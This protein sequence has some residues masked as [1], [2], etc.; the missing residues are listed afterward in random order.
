MSWPGSEHAQSSPRAVPFTD[1]M[2]ANHDNDDSFP[3]S[4]SD[5]TGAL[6]PLPSP[7]AEVLHK[8]AM[9]VAPTQEDADEDASSAAS[10]I[11]AYARLDF[12][13]YTFFVQTLQVVLGR[14][15]N[16]EIQSSQHAVDVH[17][18]SKKA[19]SRRHAKIFYNFGT[20]QFEISIMGRNGA[21]VDDLFVEKGITLPLVDGTKVQIGDIS[22]TFVLP[23]IEPSEENEKKL[24][25]GQLINPSDAINLRTNLYQSSTSP[26]REKKKVTLLVEQSKEFTRRNSK[27]DIVRRL[28]TARRKSTATTNDEINALLKE[29]EELEGEN[30]DDFDP[31]SLD[32]EVRELLQRRNSKALTQEEL[33][34]EEDEIDELVRQH[35]LQQGVIIK[36]SQPEETRPQ[37]QKNS[38]EVDIDINILDQEIASLA[39]LIDAHNEGLDEPKDIIKELDD[40]KKVQAS[41]AAASYPYQSKYGMTTTGSAPYYDPNTDPALLR[42]A[43]LMGRPAVGPR[44]G[45]P[46]TIQPPANRVYGRQPPNIGQPMSPYPG[47]YQMSSPL[48]P[49]YGNYVSNGASGTAMYN[50]MLTRLPPPKLEVLVETISRIPV[51]NSISP[52]RAITSPLGSFEKAPICVFKSLDPPITKPKIPMRRKEGAIRKAP[53]VQSYK[54][55]PEQFK[56]KPTVAVLAMITSV[57]KPD[58]NGKKYLTL[59]EIYEE[60]KEMFPYYKFCPDGWQQLVTHNVRF[61]QVF[62]R[63]SKAG[64]ESEWRWELDEDYILEKENT[65]KRQ[66]ELA[67]T[68]AKEAA[69]K[70]VEFRQ[71]QRLDVPQ[72]SSIGRTF[73]GHESSFGGGLRYTTPGASPATSVSGYNLQKSKSI[74]EI[75]SEIKRDGTYASGK[76]P[77]YLHR[78]ISGAAAS[79]DS[80]QLTELEQPSTGATIKDQLAANRA[81]HTVSPPVTRVV[82]TPLQTSSKPQTASPS[83]PAMTADTKKSLTYLQKELFTLYKARK[84]SYSTLVTTEI[85]TKALATTIAQVN[86]IGSKAGCGDNALS[87]LVEKAPQQVSKI[88]DIALTKSIKEKQGTNTP[89]PASRDVTPLP[90]GPPQPTSHSPSTSIPKTGSVTEVAGTPQ[91]LSRDNPSAPA[92]R[93]KPG[94][95]LSKP[96]SFV[97]SG[98]SRPTFSGK[99][100]GF[101]KPGAL[102]KPPQFI[103]NKPRLPEKRAVDPTADESNKMAKLG[104]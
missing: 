72:Y 12:E 101:F 18:G 62:K 4:K 32:E 83:L 97:G 30:D 88:L 86:I 50:P 5:V 54:E 68:K 75:A 85:I 36:D 73:M 58:S 22:F 102:T 76:N 14:N 25:P 3:R 95:V 1:H 93:G 77:A 52:F 15:F 69:L 28:S 49:A 9:L 103:S 45:K 26:L 78:Q 66:Q 23:S 89:K 79:S 71:R 59:N 63:A 2:K 43:P 64:L 34:Q 56:N 39:P 11:S 60:I 7:N 90:A 98:L 8:L 94:S 65:R 42:N 40:R 6:L 31:S 99:P 41:A 38:L 19:I 51:V 16:E 61:N 81:R 33:E 20:Q 67:M 100:Q 47:S 29:L 96:P 21:F 57:L 87:F 24:K 17:L 37:E 82:N 53:R 27:A 13:D 70:A 10:R 44:M 46:A 74:A 92:F 91:E 84:L 48:Y 104:S 55:I 80:N 35:N